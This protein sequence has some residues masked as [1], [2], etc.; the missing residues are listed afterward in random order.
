MECSCFTTHTK[1]RVR[2]IIQLWKSKLKEFDKNGKVARLNVGNTI[3]YIKTHSSDNRSINICH[4]PGKNNPSHSCI[5]GYDVNNNE[6]PSLIALSIMEN[7]EI[8]TFL[9]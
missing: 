1:Q 9:D 8:E 4:M 2:E 6:I 7:Y 3:E 5:E